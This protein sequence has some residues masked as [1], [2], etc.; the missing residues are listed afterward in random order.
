MSD[1]K[2][3]PALIGGAF[4]RAFDAQSVALA[5]IWADAMTEAF[6]AG[7][8]TRGDE[9]VVGRTYT[10]R[11]LAVALRVE[12]P[13]VS[14]DLIPEVV[15]L[16]AHFDECAGFIFD[17]GK[18]LGLPPM[19]AG[20][21]EALMARAAEL[22]AATTAKPKRNAKAKAEEAAPKADL[23]R[24]KAERVPCPILPPIGAEVSIAY[25]V[26]G[27]GRTASGG[28]MGHH[29]GG[30]LRLTSVVAE[31]S[32]LTRW[33]LSV[34]NTAEAPRGRMTWPTGLSRLCTVTE[35]MMYQDGT[36]KCY[37]KEVGGAAFMCALNG[38]DAAT[39]TPE[40]GAIEAD[41]PD[42]ITPAEQDLAAGFDPEDVEGEPQAD[43]ASE[44]P[45]LNEPLAPADDADDDWENF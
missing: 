28:V 40:G 16:A 2:Q 34:G 44:D 42:A 6:E 23:A 11:Q 30:G 19:A 25:T 5:P 29:A 14:T 18:A 3:L 15:R 41:A 20:S 45:R 8:N 39:W 31:G 17:L 7:K 12:N 36:W 33:G 1:T 22:V 37:P 4:L 32:M 21:R 26:D 9:A 24:P 27:A 43:E 38:P 13:D 10:Q 35:L